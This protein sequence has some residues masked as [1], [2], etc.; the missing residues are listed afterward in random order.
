DAGLAEDGL[1]RTDQD[2]EEEQRN[3]DRRK[4]RLGFAARLSQGAAG[5]A[6]HVADEAGPLGERGGRRRALRRDVGWGWS[7][8]GGHHAAFPVVAGMPALALCAGTPA[9]APSS[10]ASMC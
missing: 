3:E 4:Q 10:P 9:L 7:R 5:D 8:Q 1:Q 6:D 2:R